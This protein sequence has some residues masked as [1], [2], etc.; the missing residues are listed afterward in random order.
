[1]GLAAWAGS[2]GALA[3]GAVLG[4]V[5]SLSSALGSPFTSH[6]LAPGEGV[7]LLEFAAALVGTAWA[8]A[9]FAFVAGWCTPVGARRW[10][11]RA[12]GCSSPSRPTIFAT[13]PWGSTSS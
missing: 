1:M 9:V 6:S 2:F 12:Q 5:N 4:L 3:G 8:W 10:S 11:T 7:W 13:R